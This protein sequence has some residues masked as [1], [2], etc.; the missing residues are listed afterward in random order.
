MSDAKPRSLP[1]GND[2]VKSARRLVRSACQG[3]LAT[4]DRSTGHP[5]AS[6]VATAT[7]P[8]GTPLV[9]ISRLAV[10]TQNLLHD[11]RASLLFSETGHNGDPLAQA[12][13]T[14]I[15]RIGPN[16]SATARRRFLARHLSAAAYADFA[17]FTFHSMTIERVHYVG[18]FGRILELNPLHLLDNLECARDLIEAEGQLVEDLNLNH[19]A[20]LEDLACGLGMPAKPVPVLV[21]I[22]PTGFDLLLAQRVLRVD[23]PSPVH[24]REAAKAAILRITNSAAPKSSPSE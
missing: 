20:D 22:D 4:L 11:Q 17:D 1:A 16:S 13:V 8:D 19:A 18:G 2:D 3:A 7:E 15:G 6:L 21:A 5:H 23:F 12:R 14:L 24:N 10:H 9:L